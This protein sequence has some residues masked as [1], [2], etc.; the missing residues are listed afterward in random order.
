MTEPWFDPMR[1]S[2]LPGTFLGV[3][4]GVWGVLVGVL[5][6]QGKARGLIFAFSAVLFTAS[7]SLLVAGIVAL[8]T[9]QPYGVWYGLGLAGFIGTLV[10]GFNI[11]NLRAVYRR[12]EER[13]MAANDARL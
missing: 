7:V 12:A 8:L 2:W 4:A 13:K 9:G 11:P 10:L 6:P 3:L 1:Y 5:A